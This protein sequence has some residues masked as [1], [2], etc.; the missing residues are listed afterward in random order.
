MT[1][2]TARDPSPCPR[3]KQRGFVT[4]REG[5]KLLLRALIAGGVLGLMQPVASR[6]EAPRDEILTKGKKL[7]SAGNEE[8]IIRHFFGDRR[9]GFFLDVGAFKWKQAST[10]LYLERHLGWSGIAID[11]QAQYAEGYKKHRPRTRFFVYLVTDHSGDV[12][13]LHL[14]GPL[15]SLDEE[16]IK[17]FVELDPRVESFR[18]KTVEVPT[19]TLDDL[20]DRSGVKKIDFLSMDIEGAEPLALAGC[21]LERFHPALVCIEVNLPVREEIHAYFLSHGYERI[22]AYKKHD[23][24]NWYYRPKA[25]PSGESEH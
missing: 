21:D 22:D 23:R 18:P 12:G 7:Y 13:T 1:P 2:R 15:S 14:A 20:L 17:S 11:A 9:Q 3:Q 8:L 5:S 19:I 4:R 24:V 25:K 6:A 10:T 16:H